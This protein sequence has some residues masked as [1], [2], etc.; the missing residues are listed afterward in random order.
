MATQPQLQQNSLFAASREAAKAIMEN[1][2]VLHYETEEMSRLRD[3][4]K[5]F[6]NMSDERFNEIKA[7]YELMCAAR[8]RLGMENK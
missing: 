1:K 8:R 2:P 4:L 7:G 3:Y 5:S 6:Y